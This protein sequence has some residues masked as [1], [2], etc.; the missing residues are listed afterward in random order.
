[1]AT[2]FVAAT[3]GKSADSIA[4]TSITTSTPS[5]TVNDYILCWINVNNG[6]GTATTVTPPAGWTTIGTTTD[7]TAPILWAGLFGRMV[8]AGDTTSPVW[9]FSTGSNATWVMSAYS[10][11]DA[12]TPYTNQSVDP[13][14]GSTSAKTTAT[15]TTSATGW[16]VSGFGDRSQGIYT[17][18]TDTSRATSRQTAYVTPCSE[19][20]Q[21]SNGDVTAGSQ[22]RTATGPSG[23]SVGTSFIVRLNPGV[24]TGV[25]AGQAAGTG[26]AYDVHAIHS[27][28][29]EWLRDIGYKYI[30]HRGGSVDWVEMTADAY[31]HVDA[32]KVQAIEISVWKTSDGV[33]VASHDQS[34]TRMFGTNIDIPTNTYASLTGLTTTSGGFPMARLDDLLALYANSNH[35]IFIDNKQDANVTTFLD[36]LD[37]YTNATGIFIVK[38]YYSSSATAVAAR[39]RGYTTWGYYYDTDLGSLDATEGKY[40]LLGLNYDASGGNWTTIKA[41]GKPVFAHVALSAANAVTAFA[42]GADGVVTG[43]ILTVVPNAPAAIPTGVGTA[44]DA[45]VSFTGNSFANAINADAT[46]TAYNAVVSGVTFGVASL[47]ALAT[48]SAFDATV[49]ANNAPALQLFFI[50]PTQ[51]IRYGLATPGSGLFRR[52]HLDSGYTV[53]RH[54]SYTIV[55]NPSDTDI[56]TADGVYLGGRHHGIDVDEANRLVA[57]GFGIWISDNLADDPDLQVDYNLYH[58]GPY[59]NG[60]YGANL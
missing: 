36:L 38:Q 33:W 23:T 14:A 31:S 20:L 13:Y 9:S 19:V 2:A 46:G 48:G 16:I 24:A 6:T 43:K 22:T 59:G 3:T 27:P 55:S 35:I 11:L 30:A 39:L 28:L 44:Y 4:D 1:M 49:T 32:L 53:L 8:Q 60:P 54:V 29:K 40:D 51:R 47:E 26:T 18:L 50:T 45:T 15:V 17:A 34:T 41:K 25:N 5:S 42:T 56:A 52:L 10:G 37:T 21:D 7:G 12:T 57:A 58:D